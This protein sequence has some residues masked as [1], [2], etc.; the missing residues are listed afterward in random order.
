M[1]VLLVADMFQRIEHEILFSLADNG[2]RVLIKEAASVIQIPHK[3][4]AFPHHSNLDHKDSNGDIPV[5]EDVED[6]VSDERHEEEAKETPA[7]SYSR[8]VKKQLTA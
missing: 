2:Y 1:K 7:K 5:F 4:Q 8:G 3:L 6:D